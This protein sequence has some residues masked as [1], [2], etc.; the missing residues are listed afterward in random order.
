MSNR[1]HI[2]VYAF[3]IVISLLDCLLWLTVMLYPDG[4]VYFFVVVRILLG[5]SIF[6]LVNSRMKFVS[7][8]SNVLG[9][10]TC[11]FFMLFGVLGIAGMFAVFKMASNKS[12][13][14]G[15]L[16]HIDREVGEEVQDSMF[17][18]DQSTVSLAELR[19]VAPLTDS[20]TD[21]HEEIRI[22]AIQAMEDIDSVTM[23]KILVESRNDP[24]KE[25][26][27]Y[28]NE[29]LEKL[30]N[31][32]TAKIKNLLKIINNTCDPGY[33][34][35]KQLA[36]VY[37][38][39]ATLN[40]EPPNLNRFYRQQSVKYYSH[41]LERY[42]VQRGAILE[43]FIPVLYQNKD[44]RQCLEYCEEVSQ[45]PEFASI[46]MLYKIR[47]LFDMRQILSL[48]QLATNIKNSKALVKAKE[49]NPAIIALD[50][51]FEFIG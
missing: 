48:K 18:D 16:Y 2:Q 22:A 9:L 47:C 6:F 38:E 20:M 23:R 51:F 32:Y 12:Y 43:K 49:K 46:S 25:V 27:Y 35:Y 10:F 5:I 14:T 15:I 31:T 36:D 28:A 33:E 21:E 1:R 50:N 11:I 34:T 24:S 40:I 4:F 19:K 41:L 45:T 29:A 13:Q 8:N 39:F 7:I 44:Y 26:R 17:P 42:P 3:L 37:A 30:S